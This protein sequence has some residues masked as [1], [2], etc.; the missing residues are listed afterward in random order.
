MICNHE[1]VLPSTRVITSHLM[2]S[3]SASRTIAAS[4][5]SLA[6]VLAA[7]ARAD[8]PERRRQDMASA[9]RSAARALGRSPEQV[10]ADPRLL[11]KRLTE[12]APQALG[13]SRGRWRNIRS[14]LRAALKLITDGSTR[15]ASHAADARL[16]GIVGFARVADPQDAAVAPVPLLQSRE[17]RAGEG[18]PKPPSTPS[19][20]TWIRRC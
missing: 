7:V 6:D 13:L 16:E 5:P 3:T 11:G 1:F 10:P 12:V 8:L 2:S 18:R 19:A 15:P 9:V 17:H 4:P 20:R 14:L